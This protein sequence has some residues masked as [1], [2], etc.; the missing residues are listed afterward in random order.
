[1]AQKSNTS[2]PKTAMHKGGPVAR[3]N[4]FFI[5]IS[6]L[7]EVD[8]KGKVIFSVG[9]KGKRIAEP[10]RPLALMVSFIHNCIVTKF[11]YSS[12][13]ACRKDVEWLKEYASLLASLGSEKSAEPEKRD[14]KG[15]IG[16]PG[17]SA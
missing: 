8:E 3:S 4:R 12:G 1:M 10:D 11:C 13:E 16:R 9:F 2:Q 6:S 17:G 5:Q 14:K 7:G 15:R